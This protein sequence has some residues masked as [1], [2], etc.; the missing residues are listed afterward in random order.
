ML[1]TKNKCPK[2]GYDGD[3]KF[4]DSF[5]EVGY[6]PLMVEV[7]CRKCDLKYEIA[8]PPWYREGEPAYGSRQ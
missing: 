8:P 2:C 1:G 6:D 3:P 4:V 7:K 5:C